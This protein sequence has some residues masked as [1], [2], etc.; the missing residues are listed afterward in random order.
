MLE[1]KYQDIIENS[2]STGWVLEPDVKA[3]MKS[4]GF[5]IPYNIVTNSFKRADQFMKD[6][7][8]PVVAKAV[9]KKILHKTEYNAVVTGLFSSDQ[10]K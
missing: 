3:L 5:D 1:K 7:G 8:C 6:A 9:S 10:L 2:K 4:Q